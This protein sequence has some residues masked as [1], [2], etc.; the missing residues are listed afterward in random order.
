MNLVV[1]IPAY[2]EGAHIS[3]IISGV[4]AQGLPVLVVDDGSQDET[5]QRA[6]MAGAVVLRH[7]VN[8]G[9][10]SALA[11][12]FG[13]ARDHRVEAVITMDADGQHDPADLP[14]FCMALARDAADLIIGQRDFSRMPPARRVANTLGSA[15]LSLAIGQAIYDNQCGYRALN[16]RALHCLTIVQGRFDAEVAMIVQ[17]AR[18]GLRIGWVPIRTIYGNERSHIHPLRDT[19]L[20]AWVVWQAWRGDGA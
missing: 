20:F 10:G 16:Q 13:W 11:T 6:Q 14:A 15:L 4:L 8:R 5:A 19:I 1:L 9:K 12:G 2:N 7:G 17:A 3:A 18:L